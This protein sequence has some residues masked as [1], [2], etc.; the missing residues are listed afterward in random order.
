[1]D[2]D[3][4]FGVYEWG[5][6]ALYMCIC[7]DGLVDG[8]ATILLQHLFQHSDVEE[9]G[10][11]WLAAT[12]MNWRN[13]IYPAQRSSEAAFGTMT[14]QFDERRNRW[15]QTTN[16]T[17][18]RVPILCLLSGVTIQMPKQRVDWKTT[19]NGKGCRM[20]LECVMQEACRCPKWFRLKTWRC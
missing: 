9:M 12:K 6:G 18:A 4:Y 8:G 11:I 20:V 15:G 19:S 17:G 13:G 7:C 16:L 3:D 5:T 2:S 1:M 14:V 10:L